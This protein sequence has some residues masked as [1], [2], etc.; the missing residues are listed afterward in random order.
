M[1]NT[2]ATFHGHNRNLKNMH[3]IVRKRP[4]PISYRPIGRANR[5]LLV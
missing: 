2:I 4:V 5:T 1:A 3:R